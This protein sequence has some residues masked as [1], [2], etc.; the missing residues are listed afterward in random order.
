VL[1]GVGVAVP[2]LLRLAYALG[3]DGT[4]SGPSPVP[5]SDAPFGTR[6]RAWAM[7]RASS[8]DDGPTDPLRSP[9]AAMAVTLLVLATAAVALVL[10]VTAGAPAKLP[11]VALSSPALFHLERMLV[12]TLVVALLSVFLIRGAFGYFPLKVSTTSVEWA[13]ATAKK[14]LK[15]TT[16][17]RELTDVVGGIAK[18]QEQLADRT[19]L[20]EGKAAQIAEDAAVQAEDISRLGDAA[21]AQS[22]TL[23]VLR[24]AFLAAVP[25][26]EDAF[27]REW[28]QLER[29]LSDG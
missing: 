1:V 26:G 11:P 5:H 18:D 23:V 21:A 15:A 27:Q 8:D 2:G 24:R 14:D 17:G 9:I 6:L 20:L 22:Q 13:V 4:R 28:E 19:T 3:G 29:E 16:A 12:A 10:S 7:R 25:G